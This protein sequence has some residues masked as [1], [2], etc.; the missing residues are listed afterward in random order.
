MKKILA[1]KLN[2]Y[3]QLC[4]PKPGAKK[5]IDD[6]NQWMSLYT[7]LCL[8]SIRVEKR[9]LVSILEGQI[10]ENVNMGLY[11]FCF[12]FRDIYK[13]MVGAIE[14]QASL[15]RKVLDGWYRDLFMAEEPIYRRSNSVVYDIGFI[16]CHHSEIAEEMDKLL[17]TCEF[18]EDPIEASIKVHLGLVKIYPY[19]R[20]SIVMGLIAGMFYLLKAGIPLPSY[21]VSEDE[22]CRLVSQWI[23]EGSSEAFMD[24]HYR[25]LLNRADT[26]LSVCRQAQEASG[27]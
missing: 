1:S 18:I 14:M 10:M 15:N 7:A 26:V 16:P 8:Q 25:S 23:N 19:G 20:E 24:M 13:S 5:W 9:T 12:R 21:P 22:Y 6:S 4:P 27:E 17:R 2:E 11:G 3:A